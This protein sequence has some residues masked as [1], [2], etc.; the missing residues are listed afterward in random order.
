VA[1]TCWEAEDLP[2]GPGIQCQSGR[3]DGQLAGHH[4][5]IKSQGISSSGISAYGYKRHFFALQNNERLS[6]PHSRPMPSIGRRCH[7]LR[8][9]DGDLSWRIVYRVD[10]RLA[11]V[12]ADKH[13]L[14]AWKQGP[15]S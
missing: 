10:G 15:I 8:I 7:E 3:S 4:L 5:A 9:N 13:P 2:S 1:R 12:V 14:S 11:P 6:M